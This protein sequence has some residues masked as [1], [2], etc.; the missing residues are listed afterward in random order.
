MHPGQGQDHSAEKQSDV[1]PYVVVPGS[2][3][4]IVSR[5][6][7]LP[8]VRGGESNGAPAAAAGDA[9]GGD[10]GGQGEGLGLYDLTE[11]DEHLRPIV[12]PLL[13]KVEGNVTQRFQEH[14]DFRK[15]WEPYQGV[16]GLTDLSSDE[17]SELVAFHRDVLAA[18]PD[19]LKEWWQGIGEHAGWMPDGSGGDAGDEGDLGGD[20]P[21][22][23]VE[24]QQQVQAMAQAVQQ[25]IDGQQT[26]ET[27]DA[28]SAAK[29]AIGNELKAL[30]AE[31]LGEG[32]EFD[33]VTR[34]SILQLALAYP[35]DPQ[36][37]AKAYQ[38]FEKIAGKVEGG[39]V[40]HALGQ[41]RAAN[42][43]GSADTSAE[44]PKT[45]AE[46]RERAKARSRATV[47]TG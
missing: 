25:L 45:F 15:T 7:W 22:Q 24:L 1:Q 44:E 47:G 26:R 32:Q 39:L 2:P 29:E 13:K 46:A 31:K 35:D 42:A 28:Q 3:G 16:D 43:G 40:E 11:V 37:I 10:G 4:Y 14:A 27:Q 17:V 6:R 36:A 5:G 33:E 20:A 30:G 19:A 23:I 9:A 18:G 12:E 8:R 34:Q 38:D 21:P 41:P